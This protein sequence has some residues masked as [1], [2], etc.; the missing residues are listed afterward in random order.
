M[1]VMS[2]IDTAQDVVEF[3]KDQHRSVKELFDQVLAAHGERRVELFTA[4][5]RMLAVHETA[6]ERI[7]HPRARKELPDGD[8]VVDE[9]LA[10]EH[11]AKEVLRELEKMDVDSA[12]FE[13]TF[14]AFQSDVLAHA[15][16]EEQHEFSVLER[17]LDD[18]ELEHMRKAVEFAEQVAPTRPHPGVESPTANLL[19]GP[20]AAMLDRVRDA[21]HGHG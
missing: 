8:A 3:L 20:F 19:A 16:A 13:S 14:R 4:L 12:E 11:K 5:R 1:A 15:N 9:R 18:T 17:S 2:S 21:L 6:E 7:V 10:E